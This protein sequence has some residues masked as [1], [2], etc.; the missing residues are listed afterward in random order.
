M[1]SQANMLCF[2][3]WEVF[4]RTYRAKCLTNI[5]LYKNKELKNIRLSSTPDAYYIADSKSMK[6]SR[7]N[8]VL[9]CSLL[10]TNLYCLSTEDVLFQTLTSAV[11][12]MASK[13]TTATSM[14]LAL[15]PRALTT[16]LAILPILGMVLY[17]KVSLYKYLIRGS[18]N[19]CHLIR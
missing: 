1:N 7:Y 2:K 11:K 12:F 19:P 6:G 8:P 17:V 15:I 5:L 18:I 14:P 3:Y 16:A 9:T 10:V 13:W 4:T